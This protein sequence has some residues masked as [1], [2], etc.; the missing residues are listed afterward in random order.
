M[1]RIVVC[2]ALI[3]AL[4]AVQGLSLHAHL[5]HA[6]DI[7]AGHDVIHVHSHAVRADVDDNGEH[8]AE[9][10]IDLLTSNAAREGVGA[11]FNFAL[12]TF[13]IGLLIA[14]CFSSHRVIVPAPIGFYSPPRYR[15][16]SPR[17]PPR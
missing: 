15:R 5:P 12:V 14:L 9:A 6:N 7:H 2:I 11:S 17:A 13:W 16:S 4:A 3:V 8:S 1:N 10:S